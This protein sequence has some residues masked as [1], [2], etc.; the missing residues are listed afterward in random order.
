[1]ELLRFFPYA[2]EVADHEI[3]SEFQT[4]RECDRQIA[5]T[6]YVLVYGVDEAVG[7]VVILGVFHGA[8]RR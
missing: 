8:R 2:Q 7:E 1:M 4:W 5:R 3:W 6:P